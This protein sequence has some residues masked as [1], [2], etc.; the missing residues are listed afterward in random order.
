ML[1]NDR[2][3]GC[4]ITPADVARELRL[5]RLDIA[6]VDR[7]LETRRLWGEKADG[8]LAWRDILLRRVAEL[9]QLFGNSG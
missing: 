3:C 1:M 6:A 2:V 9:E 8:L 7:K 5:L 4:P